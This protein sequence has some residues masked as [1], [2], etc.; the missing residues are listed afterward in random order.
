M[1]YAMGCREKMC[2]DVGIM[3]TNNVGANNKIFWIVIIV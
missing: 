3:E 1:W 2:L